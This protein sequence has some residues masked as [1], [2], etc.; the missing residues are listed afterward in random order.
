LTTKQF[1][2]QLLGLRLLGNKLLGNQQ[3]GVGEKTAAL[4]RI[5]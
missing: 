3:L 4:R 2:N 5:A 1:T